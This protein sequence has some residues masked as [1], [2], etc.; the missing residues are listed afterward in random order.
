MNNMKKLLALLLALMMGIGLLA[1]PAIAEETETEEAVIPP[2]TVLASVAGV[3]VTMAQVEEMAHQIVDYYY[4]YYG[5][6]ISGEEMHQTVMEVA[7]NAVIQDTVMQAKG[8]ELGVYSLTEEEIASITA[9][10][11]QIWEDAIVYKMENSFGITAESTEEDKAIARK[12]AEDMLES[13]GY[14]L[15]TMIANELT[16]AKMEKLEAVMVAGAAVTEEEIL[17][18]YEDQ[19]AADKASYAEDV[20]NYEYSQ[21]YGAN[22][23]YVPAGYRGVLQILLEVD[24]DLLDVYQSL[25]TALET[26]TE[27]SETQVTQEQVDVAYEEA[28]ASIQPTYDEI[29]AQ[30]QAG[31]AFTDLIAKYNIDPG[32]QDEANLAEGYAVHAESIIYDPSFVAAAFSVDEIGQF[33]KPYLGSYGAYVVYYLRDIPAGAVELTET[34]KTAMEE[35]LLDNKKNELYNQTLAQ[36]MDEVVV[37]YTEAGMAFVPNEE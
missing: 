14:T 25:K 30:T 1:V 32:M 34:M 15:E 35:E 31:T 12:D 29:V 9:E 3:D 28:M 21:Y 17:A 37:T 11:E 26:Q 20:G 22:P 2:E 6:D 18:A 33:S 19:V 27:E 10:L 23:L 7:L 24:Q 8:T 5:A 13:M 4:S 36:W 16:Y